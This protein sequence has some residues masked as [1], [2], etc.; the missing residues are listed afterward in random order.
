MCIRFE[1]TPSNQSEL[2]IQTEHGIIIFKPVH[3]STGMNA[4]FC[5]VFNVTGFMLKYY[6]KA[7][8][9]PG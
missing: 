1:R 8:Y 7:I 4:P 6:L 9:E 3:K 5:T 2:S